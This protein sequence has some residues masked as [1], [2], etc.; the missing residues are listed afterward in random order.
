VDK[1]AR[2][3]AAA[4]AEQILL[5]G[6]TH[7][8]VRDMTDV[9]FHSI[10]EFDLRGVGLTAL[11]EADWDGKGPRRPSLQPASAGKPWNVPIAENRFFT[12]RKRALEE[13]DAAFKKGQTVAL[14]GLPGVGKT[15]TAARY[16]YS[17]RHKHAAVL[18]ASAASRES[19]FA[20]FAAIARLLKLPEAEAKE[21]A[22][23]LG[24]VKRWLEA[25]DRWL[26]LLDNADELDVA[27]DF[28]R[29]FV[30]Q[31]G[32][33]STLLT[34]RAPAV[35]TLAEP[36]RLTRWSPARALSFCCAARA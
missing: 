9:K 2:V 8:L 17:H 14:Y 11:W 20:D 30:P 1:A 21:Q 29:D 23:V 19:L 6:P 33:G 15:Q 31:D 32:K 27:R 4:S 7:E 26:L 34:T 3:E 12:G 10:G 13:I 25:N 16:A 35:R 28:L 5:S 24:S 22:V 18:W 36:S